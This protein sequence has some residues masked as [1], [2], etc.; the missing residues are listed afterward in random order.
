MPNSFGRNN[1]DNEELLKQNMDA[2]AQEEQEEQVQEEVVEEAPSYEEPENVKKP[3]IVDGWAHIER[4]DMPHG[5]KLY[6][7]TWEFLYRCPTAKE[8]VTFSTLENDDTPNVYIAVEDLIKKCVKIYDTD[9]QKEVASTE[10]NDSDRVFFMIK[11]REFYIADEKQSLKLHHVCQSCFEEF[12]TELHPH[13]LIYDEPSEA[14][15]EDFDGRVFR[16]DMGQM[17]EFRIP[18]ISTTGRFFR[19]MV[20]VIRDNQR[21]PS[22]QSR[23][24]A[25][26]FYDKTFLKIAPFLFVTGRES[27]KEIIAKYKMI[28]KNDDLISAYMEIIDSLNIANKEYIRAKC[29]KCEVED[30]VELSFPSWRNYFK[31]FRDKKGYFNKNS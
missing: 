12:E 11:L 24:D 8:V 28:E 26:I 10:I 19:H 23:R 1:P 25:K 16:L 6:P 15:L 13:H 20:Q 27:V 3:N 18:T 21:G 22:E 17:V 29:P 31:K 2:P 5:G 7:P 14:L 9:L 4:A 30:T